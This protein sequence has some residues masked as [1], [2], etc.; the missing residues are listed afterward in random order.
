MPEFFFV[1]IFTLNQNYL[2]ISDC[3]IEPKI[4]KKQIINMY[5]YINFYATEF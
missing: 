3:L 2:L 4:K 1:S 5:A